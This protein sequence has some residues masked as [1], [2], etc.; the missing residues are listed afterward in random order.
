MVC[1]LVHSLRIFLFVLESYFNHFLS[2]YEIGP[3]CVGQAGL[4]LMILPPPLPKHWNYKCVPPCLA[5]D[6]DLKRI[7]RQKGGTFLKVK[8]KKKLLGT[9]AHTCNPRYLGHR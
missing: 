8:K 2:F 3:Y 5:S 4:K 9:V 6:N 1:I 7:K